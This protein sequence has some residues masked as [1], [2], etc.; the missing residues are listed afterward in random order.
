MTN[1]GFPILEF[2]PA[3]SAVIEP[4][5][6]ITPVTLP[7]LAVACFF[8]DVVDGVVRRQK[9]VPRTTQRSEMGEHPI[10]EIAHR[11]RRL[12]LFHPGTGGPL[13]A[14]LIEGI[15]AHGV[16]VIVACG[17]AGAVDPALPLGQ[18]V[19]PTAAIRDEGTSYHYLPPS[20]EVAASPRGVAILEE[21]LASQ[22]IPY[23][24]GKTW[25][26]DAVFRETRAKVEAR[27]SEGALV[28]E[29][30]AATLF[31]VGEFRDVLVAQL[32]YAGDSVG[33]ESWDHR[34]WGTQRSLRKN[35]FYL[36][37]EACYRAAGVRTSPAP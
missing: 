36:A 17:G 23:L 12:A 29:M 9:L 27:R 2:D 19:V 26:T 30:E 18:V 34:E 24:C 32:L 31:A 16:K 22:G 1:A 37:C 13:V 3:R 15:I 35:L 28:V 4:R 5:R 25:T 21:L 6:T 10:Y 33:G 11:E 7:E 8:K 14:G 20:R